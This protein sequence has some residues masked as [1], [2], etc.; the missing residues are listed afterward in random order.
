MKSCRACGAPIIG[1]TARRSFCPDGPCRIARKRACGAAWA[2]ANRDAANASSRKYYAKC[3]DRAK[4]SVAQ[5]RLRNKERVKAAMKEATL[6]WKDT[7][8]NRERLNAAKAA[9][10][11]LLR[12]QKIEAERA[13]LEAHPEEVARRERARKDSLRATKQRWK[14]ANTAALLAAA[15]RRRARLR[16]GKSP[17]VTAAQWAEILETFGH[18]C[19]YCLKT[20]LK[21]T[22]DHV[23]PI[24][25]GGLDSP[26]NVVPACLPCNLNKNSKLLILWATRR[27]A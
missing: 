26:E 8:G 17:G 10:R 14:E 21:L 6:R 4:E 13:Y 2:A 3:T 11:A 12:E 25:R 5:Y 27:A 15:H 1:G 20:G 22:R 9:K 16:D 23:E 7:N 24:A 19:A 18:A